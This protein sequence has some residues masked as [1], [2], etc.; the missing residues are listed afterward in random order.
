M[1]YKFGERDAVIET[2]DKAFP[3]VLRDEAEITPELR[4]HL[5]YP[6]D[7]FKVQRELLGQY[8]VTNPAT[9]FS[10]EDQWGIPNDPADALNDQVANQETAAP[11]GPAAA[12]PIDTTNDGPAQPPYYSSLQFPDEDPATED[13]ARFRLST[14]FVFRSRPNLAAFASVS[15]DQQDYGTIRVLQLPRGNPPNG[16]TQVA[17][18][19]L[20]DPSVAEELF[21]FR[22]N[23]AD[24]SF[25]NLLTLPQ[26]GGLLYVQP[27]YVQAQG[28]QGFPTLQQVLVAYGNDVAAAPTLSAALQELLDGAP[29]TGPAPA[30]TTPP[31][32]APPTP[33]P[34]PTPPA[35][36]A[37]AI[38]QA[39]Q[40]FRD[41]QAAFGRGDFAAYG[42]AQQ[43]LQAA[44][45]RLTQLQ[46]RDG[47]ARRLTRPPPVCTPAPAS[48]RLSSSRRGVEQLGS[49]LGS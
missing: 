49:S 24:V 3:G 46:G 39:D 15:S 8:H 5:R 26:A 29:S 42:Q 30:E 41:G 47:P 4:A 19:F 13:A 10:R 33:G 43:R 28:G 40:A 9:F 20:T 27:V 31:P 2:W 6:E 48:H 45:A 36:L 25:G 35:D 38:A 44:L 32:T 17:N 21:R 11:V 18:L 14:S 1:L 22:R 12:A 16:P 37:A 23:N 7:L 34:T